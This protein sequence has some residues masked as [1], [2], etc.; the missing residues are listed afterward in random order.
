MAPNMIGLV[1]SQAER[2]IP[3]SFPQAH[4]KGHM[5]KERGCPRHQ[6]WGHPNPRLPASG[7]K[8]ATTVTDEISYPLPVADEPCGHLRALGSNKLASHKFLSFKEME[9]IAH[10]YS[11]LG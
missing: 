11:F 3:L 5:S 9:I 7:P 1:S 6:S 10:M 2:D 4:R 8:V